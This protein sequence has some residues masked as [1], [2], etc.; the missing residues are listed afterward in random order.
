MDSIKEFVGIVATA[1]GAMAVASVFGLL[2][3]MLLRVRCEQDR[4]QRSDNRV[5]RL[6]QRH[7]VP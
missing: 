3:G 6:R 1:F 2:F 5:Q 7:E 4:K